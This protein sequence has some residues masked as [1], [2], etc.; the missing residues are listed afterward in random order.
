MTCIVRVARASEPPTVRSATRLPLATV[1]GFLHTHLVRQHKLVL[2]QVLDLAAQLL[3][4]CVVVGVDRI[5]L[6]QLLCQLGDGQL[7]LLS[8]QVGKQS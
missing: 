3:D 1:T 6:L 8:L 4:G 7:Q 5:A 2:L